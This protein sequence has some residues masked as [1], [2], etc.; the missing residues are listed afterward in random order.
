MP[1]E[2][3]ALLNAV[4]PSSPVL[5]RPR[6]TP[7]SSQRRFLRYRKRPAPCKRALPGPTWSDGLVSFSQFALWLPSSTNIAAIAIARVVL[8]AH[9]RNDHHLIPVRKDIKLNAMGLQQAEYV[10]R[11]PKDIHFDEVVCSPLIRCEAVRI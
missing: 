3:K 11:F 1:G 2:A 10:G 7:I 9:H 6:S 5:A 4:H 8:E